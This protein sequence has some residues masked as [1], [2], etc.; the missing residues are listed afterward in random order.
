MQ[1]LDYAIR[2]ENSN[3]ASQLYLW[4]VSRIH[5]SKLVERSIKASRTHL[6]VKMVLAEFTHGDTLPSGVPVHQAMHAYS[7]TNLVSLFIPRTRAYI[8]RK[9]TPVGL[10]A[11]TFQLVVTWNTLPPLLPTPDLQSNAM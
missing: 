3:V 1:T 2:T 6:P 7:G 5:M 11:D 10:S 9:I 4:I 8:R